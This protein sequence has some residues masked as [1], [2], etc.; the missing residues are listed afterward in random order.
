MMMTK[1]MVTT[2]T[3]M[4]MMTV[5][6]DVTFFHGQCTAYRNLLVKCEHTAQFKA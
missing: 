4:M 3:T 2:T 5:F 1:T 6:V